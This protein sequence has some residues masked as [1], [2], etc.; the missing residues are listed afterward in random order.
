MRREMERG[1]EGIE[2][3]IPESLVREYTTPEG[4]KVREVGPIV[5]PKERIKIEEFTG[6]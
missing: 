5:F 2:K 3:R 6:Y 4:G 1:F